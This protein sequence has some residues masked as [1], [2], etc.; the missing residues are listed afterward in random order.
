VKVGVVATGA[1]FA[2]QKAITEPSAIQACL[3]VI[4]ERLLSDTIVLLLADL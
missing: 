4:G 3:E 1:A 2:V